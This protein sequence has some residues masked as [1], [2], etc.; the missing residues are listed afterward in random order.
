MDREWEM[1][2][3]HTAT[4]SVREETDPSADTSCASSSC[5]SGRHSVSNYQ[6][7]DDGCTP[8]PMVVDRS[9]KATG[10]AGHLA[11]AGS[12]PKDPGLVEASSQAIM[13]WVLRA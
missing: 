1:G 6:R 13:R 11:A 8:A 4:L 3:W 12:S 9:S 2:I 5:G 10:T 7:N